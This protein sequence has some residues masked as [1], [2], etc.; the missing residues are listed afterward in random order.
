[1]N[2]VAV[3]ALLFFAILINGISANENRKTSFS[4]GVIGAGISSDESYSN[5]YYYGN[6]L[7]FEHTFNDRL[8]LKVSPLYFNWNMFDENIFQLT[9]L[10]AFLSYNLL[11]DDY[12][13]LGPSISINTFGYNDLGLINLN[14]GIVFS[15]SIKPSTTV[16]KYTC[17]FLEAGVKYNTSTYSIY[18][19]VGVDLL[20][21][22]AVLGNPSKENEMAETSF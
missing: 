22:L 4:L 21:L 7:C 12:I 10:N 9:F 2:K 14:A 11:D 5:G 17:I 13:F 20:W 3:L 18:S 19:N 8:D 1:M 15:I 16:L 6:L